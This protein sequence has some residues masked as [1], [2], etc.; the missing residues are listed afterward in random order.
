[1]ITL[2]YRRIT[3]G[4]NGYLSWCNGY[5]LV[6]LTFFAVTSYTWVYYRHGSL[7]NLPSLHSLSTALQTQTN[8]S[9]I[10]LTALRHQKLGPP[11]LPDQTMCSAACQIEMNPRSPLWETQPVKVWLTGTPPLAVGPCSGLKT[12]TVRN[13]SQWT[14]GWLTL[15]V[16]LRSGL[17]TPTENKHCKPASISQPRGTH[18]YTTASSTHWGHFLG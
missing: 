12:P 15:I 5:H 16:G 4:Y 1:M 7:Q 9:F 14:S 18:H 10:S 3:S 6:M 11:C 13:T 8:I 17:K 2:H